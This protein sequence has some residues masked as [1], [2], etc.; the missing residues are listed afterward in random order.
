MKIEWVHPTWRDLVIGTLVANDEA[1]RH[2]LERCGVHGF[3]LA[4]STAGGAAGERTLP[5]LEDDA[6]WDVLT[7]R[8]Y[9]LVAELEPAE[10]IAALSALRQALNELNGHGKGAAWAG[11]SRTA[12]NDAVANREAHA[13][14]R[15]ALVRSAALWDAR[16]QPIPLAPLESW[17]ALGALLDPLPPA[18]EMSVT[19]AEL[20]PAAV[21]SCGD[22][23]AIERFVDW[24]TLCE[25]LWAYDPTLREELGF[26]T[27]QL[28]LMM[29][30][31]VEIERDPE[32]ILGA[33]PE[34]AQRALESIAT[35]VPELGPFPRH[36][37]ERIGRVGADHP[38]EANQPAAPPL[39][40]DQAKLDEVDVA[41]VLADL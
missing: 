39:D 7:D 40:W 9:E 13:L 33:S 19:W 32:S 31:A 28:A 8:I 6:D 38:A 15:T 4:L 25:L 2:F 5:L 24:L 10:L 3:A 26:G 22:R 16:R 17:L 30:F 14:A 37:A 21:P 36:V 11:H 27:S 41:R 29:A 23:V 35:L 18:P 34:L 12:A 1:R 20:L